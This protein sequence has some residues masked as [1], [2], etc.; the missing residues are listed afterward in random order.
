MIKKFNRYELK[1]I[2]PVN[3]IKEMQ[4]ELMNF[5]EVD[6]NSGPDGYYIESLYFDSLNY[7]FF[8]SKI[9]GLNYRRKVR[10]RIYKGNI[11]D[12]V[13]Q[14]FLE[15][16]QRMN[17]TVQKRRVY[18]NISD[19]YKICTGGHLTAVEINELDEHD[20]QVI[21]EVRYIYRTLILRPTV[22]IAYKRYAFQGSRYDPGLRITF[23]MMLK[24]RRTALDLNL[25]AKNRFFLS[26]EYSILEVKCNDKVSRWVDFF[27]SKYNCS[28]RRVSKYCSG[29]INGE[30]MINN[31][32]MVV[33]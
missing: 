23:D 28:L 17:K 16:K 6:S 30:E 29:L 31:S 26:P 33:L 22:I 2:L 1:Y 10:I 13:T 3:T 27:L 25:N 12:V 19:A 5:M 15:I 7:D 20:I 32:R 24:Y 9:D 18:L 8:R 4:K 11:N 14:G 21:D